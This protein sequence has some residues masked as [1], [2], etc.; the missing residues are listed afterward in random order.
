MNSH[1][2]RPCSSPLQRRA[3]TLAE[4]LVTLVIIGVV[5]ALTISALIN[6]YVESSTVAKV[7]KGLSILGQAKKLAETQNGPIEGW[8][9]DAVQS[10]ANNIKFFN[11]LKPYLS[12]ARDCGAGQDCYKGQVYTLNGVFHTKEYA[13]NPNYY[14]FALADG[15]VM[16][17]ST[18]NGDGVGKCSASQGP[19]TNVC[20][21]FQYD[22]N[23]DKAPNKFGRDIFL[24]IFTKDAVYPY[25]INN[26]RKTDYG[27]GCA[28]YI[29]KN[30]NM[31]YLH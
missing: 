4:I 29:V 3:F 11:Y 2:T 19:H 21:M 25:A 27:S 5:A 9:F 14:K 10:E 1:H 13:T 18:G 22:V 12:V 24:Y 16:W 17:F 20:A 30:S 6:T 31:N 15:S 8:D 26:C 7:K 28:A 23:G